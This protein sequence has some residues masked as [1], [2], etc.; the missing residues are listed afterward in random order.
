MRSKIKDTTGA[1][2]SLKEFYNIKTLSELCSLI[3]EHEKTASSGT[4][5]TSQKAKKGSLADLLDII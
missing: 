2:I 4:V 1:D 3:D 5:S